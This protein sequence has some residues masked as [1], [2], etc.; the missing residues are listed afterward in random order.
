VNVIKKQCKELGKN[1]LSGYDLYTS[2]IP[3]SLCTAAIYY[4]SVDKVFY[5]VDLE[6]YT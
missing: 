4:A 2:L 3:C 5:A 6:E 1:N